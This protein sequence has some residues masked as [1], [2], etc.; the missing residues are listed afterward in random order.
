IA[1][2]SGDERRLE[3]SSFTDLATAFVSLSIDAAVPTA[4]SI[5]NLTADPQIAGRSITSVEFWADGTQV[6]AATA[7][8]FASSWIT[9]LPGR[10]NLRARLLDSM[11]AAYWSREI[12]VNAVLP[13]AQAMFARSDEVTRGNWRDQYGSGGMVL[14]DVVTNFSPSLKLTITNASLKAIG[15]PLNR[16]ALLPPQ[17]RRRIGRAWSAATNLSFEVTAND[18][19]LY[20]ISLYF[21]DWN[22]LNRRACRVELLDQETGELLEQRFIS[23]FRRGRYCTFYVRGSVLFRIT[24]VTGPDVVLS[25]IFIDKASVKEPQ[26]TVSADRSSFAASETVG[27]TATII[28]GDV[29]TRTVEFRA[30]GVRI[31]S[32]TNDDAS[33]SWQ[34]PEVGDYS[35]VTRVTDAL[36]NT[37]SSTPLLLR[38]TLPPAAA[39]WA[40]L[41]S[42]TRG[43]WIGK[44]GT[45][46]YAIPA[47]RTNMGSAIDLVISNSS[48]YIFDS[49]TAESNGLELPGE[50][51][52]WLATWI[53]NP[54]LSLDLTFRDGRSHF[55]TF[56]FAGPDYVSSQTV[57]VLDGAT[58]E[59]LDARQVDSFSHGLY[60]SWTVRGHVRF[61]ITS[62]LAPP[63]LLSGIFVDPDDNVRP[64]VAMIAPLPLFTAEAP[65]TLLLRAQATDTDGIRTVRFYQEREMIGEATNAP[66]EIPWPVIAGTPVIVAK[67]ID[68]RGGATVSE[69]ISGTVALTNAQVS[70]AGVDVETSGNWIGRYGSEG[71]IIAGAETNLPH[72]IS[73]SLGGVPV[74]Y[75]EGVSADPRALQRTDIFLRVASM[76]YANHGSFAFEIALKDGAPHRLSLYFLDWAETVQN[77]EVEMRAADS[78]ELLSHK[79]VQQFGRGAYYTWVVQGRVHITVKGVHAQA[80]LSGIFLDAAPP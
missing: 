5:L 26:V 33:L 67:A 49:A 52:R 66:Y 76:W 48:E 34:A 72:S 51:F 63:T 21:V 44:Y 24:Q 80:L 13:L 29:A 42:E 30:N 12:P 73:V 68:H 58:G 78:G 6:G 64:T 31:G 36:G 60:L 19:A 47:Y 70:F 14:P 28:P 27:L 20:A 79:S 43:R 62:D 61:R 69:P 37:V 3:A 56:Y 53:R 74:W 17:G 11:G 9:P 46:G 71:F 18:G 55:V 39:E 22:T 2:A 25:G 1:V 8:P 59:W 38:A 65:S 75:W 77:L 16:R 10:Y 23:K 32:T 54:N 50:P 15:R 4:G 40:N 45:E 7:A 35:V 41:D 57:Q